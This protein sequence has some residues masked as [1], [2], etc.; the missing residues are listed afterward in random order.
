MAAA[1]PVNL[2]LHRPMPGVSE[3][4]TKQRESLIEQ[5]VSRQ[6]VRAFIQCRAGASAA[7]AAPAASALLRASACAEEPDAA[8]ADVCSVRCAPPKRG[9]ERRVASCC[10]CDGRACGARGCRRHA[11]ASCSRRLIDGFA[12]AHASVTRS[13]ALAACRE[14]RG[15]ARV[16]A[17]HSEA[18]SRWPVHL[19]R[20]RHGD[21]TMRE[22]KAPHH[23][24]QVW[25]V[26]CT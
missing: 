16:W 10:C 18:R 8:A 15:R 4:Q 3:S 24:L 21:A 22:N 14:R 17:K 6:K 12:S 1:A 9:L 2:F 13:A 11:A 7:G 5:C 23:A 19:E 25:K 20:D 26:C